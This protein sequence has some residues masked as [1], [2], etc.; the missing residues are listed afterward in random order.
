VILSNRV[1]CLQIL[2]FLLWSSSGFARGARGNHNPFTDPKL[3][4]PEHLI[5]D[6]LKF[7]GPKDLMLLAQ[8]SPDWNR[9]INQR[10]IWKRHVP[11]RWEMQQFS[12]YIQFGNYVMARKL[13]DS[14]SFSEQHLED[15]QTEAIEKRNWKKLGKLLGLRNLINR[16]L[17]YRK[18][19]HCSVLI[20]AIVEKDDVAFQELLKAGAD[21]NAVGGGGWTPVHQASWQ[22]TGKKMRSAIQKLVQAG[23]NINA[24]GVAGNTPLHIAVSSGNADALEVLL[25]L[26]A[27][28]TVPN[29]ATVRDGCPRME[30]LTPVQMAAYYDSA[31]ALRI[32]IKKGVNLNQIHE[33]TRMTLR[34]LAHHVDARAKTVEV[35]DSADDS[36]KK[37]NPDEPKP[38]LW[39]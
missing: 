13:L 3:S 10:E 32:F 26:G 17:I 30:K 28:A 25:D 11:Q 36:Q 21:P 24:P 39:D 12:Q 29:L 1:F 16:L 20:W 4:I 2:F 8:A 6:V 15:L 18:G 22:F 7:L 34:E 14:E 35:I 31:W 38:Y 9:V 23:A 27:D 19:I 5:P 37:K 33:S